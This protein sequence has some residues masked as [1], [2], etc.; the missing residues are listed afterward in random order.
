ME[1]LLPILK[2]I[3]S[4]I[5]YTT[6]ITL[7]LTVVAKYIPNNK[8][9]QLGYKIGVYLTTFGTLRVG[10]VWEKIET[11]FIESIGQILS[12]I[13]SGLRSDDPDQNK[14]VDK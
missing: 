3:I 7:G 5:G 4:T 2:E 12:G 13:K 10:R 11:F 6:L 14:D 1:N 9:N 8:L